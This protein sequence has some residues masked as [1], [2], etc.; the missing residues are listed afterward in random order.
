[1]GAGEARD[2]RDVEVVVVIVRDEHDVDRRQ[3]LELEA[4]RSHTLRTGEPD[5]ARA[6]RP[7]RVGQDVHPVEL[8]Q[9]RRVADPGHRGG[10]GI[11]PDRAQVAR[12][13][14]EVRGPGMNRGGP[15]AR[16]EEAEPYPA[17]G[18]DRR[19]IGVGEPPLAVMCGGARH[20][21]ADAAAGA[22]GEGEG[23][24]RDAGPDQL[25]SSPT[26]SSRRNDAPPW[27]EFSAQSRP[28]SSATMP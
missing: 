17:G 6:R 4:G 25:V 13:D 26:G 10:G 19:G 18:N 23:Q 11:G 28:P 3:V 9:E 2:G 22:Q 8:D 21:L 5:G 14:G 16:D 7:L 12:D 15:D 1:M 27:G 24:E 20:G